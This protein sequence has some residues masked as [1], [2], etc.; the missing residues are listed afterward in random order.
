MAS[1]GDSKVLGLVHPESR[2]AAQLAR[3]ARK[4]SNKVFCS[5]PFPRKAFT[6]HSNTQASRGRLKDSNRREEAEL[7]RWLQGR[8][9]GQGFA[10]RFCLFVCLFDTHRHLTWDSP[11]V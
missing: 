4:E 3:S 5:L 6:R 7:F 8:M 2:K 11:N 1:K 9:Q 10:V